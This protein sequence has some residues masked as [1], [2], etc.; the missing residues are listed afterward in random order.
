MKCP[1]YERWISD[2]LDGSVSEKRRK[3]LEGHLAQCPDCRAYHDRLSRIQVEASRPEEIK[4]SSHYWE[5]FSA[6]LDQK[7]RSLKPE[8]E[9]GILR[10]LGWR[11]AWSGAAV[12]LAAALG[13]I[14]LRNQ[15]RP[16]ENDVF[17]FEACLDR[18]GQEIGEDVKLEDKFTSLIISSLGEEFDFAGL[19]ERWAIFA[20]PF[21]WESLSDEEL[22]FVEQETTKEIK[23]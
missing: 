22:E 10:R 14:F 21:I 9:Q 16:L 15:G 23:S 20:G 12:L 17:S 5:G 18:L 19:E 2:A 7:L 6:R 3:I 1:K 4:L 11:W 13:L 8:A